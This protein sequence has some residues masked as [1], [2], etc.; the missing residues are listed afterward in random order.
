[1]MQ[2][3]LSTIDPPIND[4]SS[5]DSGCDEPVAEP[6]ESDPIADLVGDA[7]NDNIDTAEV[8]EEDGLAFPDGESFN[9]A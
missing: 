1:M 8:P 2:P 9:R 5:S 3:G 7:D 6:V 4:N